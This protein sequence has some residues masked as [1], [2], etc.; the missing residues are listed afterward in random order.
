MQSVRATNQND[1]DRFIQEPRAHSP[2]CHDFINQL[3]AEIFIAVFQKSLDSVRPGRDLARLR[4]VCHFWRTIVESTPSLWAH[5]S[6]EDGIPHVRHAVAKTGEV[7]LE[8]VYRSNEDDTAITV[9]D[10]LNAVIEKSEHWRSVE[11]TSLDNPSAYPG[12]R[13]MPCPALEKLELWCIL[14]SAP[15][16]EPF[17]L[18]SGMPAPS[19]LKELTLCKVPVQLE[20]LELVE[21]PEF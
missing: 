19:N 3:P 18:F 7:P 4:L 10:F 12:L 20:S 6:V 17:T 2:I 14:Q 5:I 13:S 15:F 8:L 21:S 1:R 16:Q 11:I 9:E